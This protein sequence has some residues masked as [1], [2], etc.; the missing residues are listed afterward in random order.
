M[1]KQDVGGNLVTAPLPLKK[2]YI[3]TYR[4]RLAHRPMKKEYEDIFELKMLLWDLRYEELK[5]NKSAPWK[6]NN[7]NKAIKRLKNNQSGDPSGLISELF[8]PGIMGQD[9]ACEVL[10]LLNGI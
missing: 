1:A 6:M 7:L 9:L 4:N 8:D 2:L 3:E 10:Q 5:S